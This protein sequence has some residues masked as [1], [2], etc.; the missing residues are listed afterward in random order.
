MYSVVCFDNSE[1]VEAVPTQ[2]YN[3][4]ACRWPPHKAEEVNRAIR[5]L[6]EPQH[7]WRLFDSARFI[8]SSDNYLECR[9]TLPLAQNQTDLTSEAEDPTTDRR[10]KRKIKPSRHVRLDFESQD[11]SP[12]KKQAFQNLPET[13]AVSGPAN[14]S[15]S[16]LRDLL[17]NQQILMDQ[18]KTMIRMIQ[19]LHRSIQGGQKMSTTSSHT[20]YFPLGDKLALEGDLGSQ[21][22]LRQELMQ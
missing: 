1:E 13:P 20:A 3:S 12:P 4:G 19:D 6:E 10:P 18:Q 15:R 9:Q 5:Q 11:P 2:W 8:F 14:I 16:L 7:T 17:V 21:R 22:D